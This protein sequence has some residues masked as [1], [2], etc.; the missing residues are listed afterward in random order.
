MTGVTL[1]EAA[2]GDGGSA[3]YAGLIAQ[4]VLD[5]LDVAARER[6]WAERIPRIQADPAA[7]GPRG[8]EH[9]L[10]V[11]EHDGRVVGWSSFGAG[12]DPGDEGRGELAGLY[13]HPSAWAHGAGGALIERVAAELSDAGFDD[14]YLWVLH[15]N[16]RAVRFYERHGWVA[17]GTEKRGSAGGADDL[18]ELRHARSLR[19]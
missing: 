12:R 8:R 1:R 4:A 11:A 2:V 18:R 16:A 9:R 17:D 13:V 10:I 7:G 6:A 15:G 5:R 14:A 3:G 19:A